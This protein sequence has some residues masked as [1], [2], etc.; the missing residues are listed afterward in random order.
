MSGRL[1]WLRGDPIALRVV[2]PGGWSAATLGLLAGVLAFFAVLALALT[3]AAGRL[4]AAWEG[5][6]GETATLQVFAGEEVIEAQARAALDVLRQTPGVRSVRMVDLAEQEK[7]L[8]PWLGPEVPM[9]SLPLPLL[10]EVATDPEVLDV[11]ALEAQLA[12]AAPGAVYDDHT[13]WRLPLVETA[14]RVG[15]F[16]LASLVLLALAL[17]AGVALAAERA[18]AV[19]AAAIRTLRLVGAEDGFI[20]GGF[21]RR[22]VLRAG[23][24]AVVGTAAG[25][26]LVALLPQGS[27]PGFFLAG[28]GLT[29]WQ[30]LLPLL[31]PVAAAGV[32]WGAARAATR[33]GLRRWS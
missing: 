11:A 33:R 2:P 9:E 29:G 23:A 12:E 8:E 17:G 26:V 13:A 32:A 30:W 7:L 6:A 28:I 27:E 19:N 4:A 3:L 25:M 10:I 15:R 5:E 20:A 31:V 16:G 18:V 24:G 14:G 1:G 21:A 22:L